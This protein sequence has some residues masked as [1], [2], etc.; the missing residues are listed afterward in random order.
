MR[1]IRKIIENLKP[2]ITNNEYKQIKN[3]LVNIFTTW[4]KSHLVVS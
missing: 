1:N 2:K 4:T 3:K